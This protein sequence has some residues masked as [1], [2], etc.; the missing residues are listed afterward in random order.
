M[1]H[2]SRRAAAALIAAGLVCGAVAPA[3]AMPFFGSS[4]FTNPGPVTPGNPTD[5]SDP[6]DTESEPLPDT[7]ETRNALKVIELINDAREDN[8]LKPL[9]VVNSMMHAAADQSEYNAKHGTKEFVT[10]FLG[11]QVFYEGTVFGNSPEAVFT[12]IDERKNLSTDT[13]IAQIGAG[14]AISSD[15]LI[16]GLVMVR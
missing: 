2:L 9:T 15:R 8:G 4:N 5:P 3:Q 12:Y 11:R 13:T 10:G 14:F 6:T 7:P 16:Y 1:S